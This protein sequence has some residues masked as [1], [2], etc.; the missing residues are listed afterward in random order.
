MTD[1][2][3]RRFMGMALNLARRGRGHVSPNP[4]VGAVIVR[5]GKIIGRGR[6]AL[7]GGPHAEVAAIADAGNCRSADIFVN[8]E[9]CSHYG[10]TP[11]CVEAVIDAGI[12]RVY[13]GM[14]DPNPLVAGEGTARLRGA[15]VYVESGILEEKC[16]DLNRGFVKYITT[17]LPLVT[18][19]AAASLDG[20]IALSG[21]QSKWITSEASRRCVQTIRSGRDAVMV[22][23]GT[24]LADDPRL[25]VRIPGLA[26]PARIVVDSMAVTPPEARLFDGK[27]KV[28]LAITGNA[29]AARVEALRDKGAWVIEAGNGRRVDLS[30]MLRMLPGLGVVS[31]LLEGGSVLATAMLAQGL[32]DDAFIFVAP[33]LLGGDGLPLLGPLGVDKIDSTPQLEQVTWRRIGDDILCHGYVKAR[34]E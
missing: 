32:I 25:D 33:K 28:I 14:T 34:H 8:L 13:V 29:P 3:K 23:S 21:G 22:G 2:D 5:D 4:M 24:V 7:Y 16:L 30:E 9:P 20:R 18:W 1:A 19:K 12:K 26:R 17:G 10:K 31:V 15:G 6:H 11:P 27:G